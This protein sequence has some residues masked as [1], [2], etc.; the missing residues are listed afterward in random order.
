MYKII[1]LHAH[2]VWNVFVGNKLQNLIKGNQWL[3]FY[4]IPRLSLVNQWLNFYVIPR[5]NFVEKIYK[6]YWFYFNHQHCGS[7]YFPV[8]ALYIVNV[9]FYLVDL[10][11]GI[12]VGMFDESFSCELIF[13]FRSSP[14]S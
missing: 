12:F 9:F 14:V 10:R 7:T 11:R 2:Q 13:A 6:V 3:N 1:T 4:V 5:P 8:F